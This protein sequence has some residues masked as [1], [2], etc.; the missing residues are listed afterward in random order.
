MLRARASSAWAR[1]SSS[2]SRIRAG[3]RSWSTSGSRRAP[4]TRPTKRVTKR[5]EAR[6]MKPSGRRPAS[7]TWVGSGVPRF[8]LPLD[9][10]FPQSNVSQLIVM[11]QDLKRRASA[12]LRAAAGA[13]GDRVPRGARPRQAAAATGRRCRTRCS[14]ASSGPTR[15]K[16]RA[17]A[18]EVKAIMRAQPEHARRQR[19]LERV[20]QGAAAGRRPGQGARAGRDQP[21]DRAGR[22][23]HQQRHHRSASTARA[24]S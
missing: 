2:S 23:H 10:I 3:R 14:S 15:R 7:R 19:Q 17:Y 21:G 1:C 6:L 13:A 24:T 8:Y 22:A 5:V 4:R 9:Q 20:G 16:V 12:L 18:D 11:P